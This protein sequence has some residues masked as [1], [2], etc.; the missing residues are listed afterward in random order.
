M[1]IKSKIEEVETV[2]EETGRE[3]YSVY[4]EGDYQYFRTETR[5]NIYP[6]RSNI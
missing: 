1:A 2:I 6:V 4:V 3:Y 5:N